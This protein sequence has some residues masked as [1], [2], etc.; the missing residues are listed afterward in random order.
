MTGGAGYAQRHLEHSDYYDERQRVR[1]EWHGRGAELLGLS[2]KVTRDQFEAVR[3]AL[4]PETGEFL[5]PRHSADRTATNGNEQSKAR[6][7]YD[8]TFS[9]PKSVSIQ[10]IVGGDDRLI[11]AHDK[12]VREAFR[13]AET[14]AA[15][16]VRLDGRN[17]N[18]I[19]AN[20][21]VAA[22]RHDASREL[23]PQ[24]HT[25]AVAANLSY[26]GVEGRWKALQASGLYERR[27][28][29]TEVYRNALAREVRGLGYDI[30]DRR[31]AKGRDYGFEIRGLSDELL[32]KYSQRSAQRDDAI[33]KFTAENGRKPTD[34][35]VAVLVR[36]SRPEK[37]AEI[38]TESVREEQ[39]TRLSPNESL[40]LAEL[41]DESFRRSRSISH[42][43]HSTSE[44]Y[45]YAKEHLFERN[46]VA[47]DHELLTE[48]LR[49]S[50]GRVDLAE[51]RG[52][53]QAEQTAGLILRSGD[54]VATR[55]SLDREK[56]I[57]AMVDKGVGQQERLGRNVP[58]A[59]AGTLREEQKQAVES[60]LD[61][62]EFAINLRGA[63]GTGKT[64]TL[65]EI[66]RGLRNAGHEVVAVAPTR[67]AVEELR[68]VG[69]QDAMTVARLLEDQTAQSSLTRK[70]LI[71]DEA[72]MISGRQMESL[73]KL[74]ERAHVRVL[75]SGDTRQIQS[76]EA[77]D[78]L[79]ILERESQMKSVS[80]NAVQRQIH[81]EYR[82][83]IQTL[84][85][86]PSQGFE[87]LDAFGAIREVPFQDRAHAIASAYREAT[88]DP[89][90][91]VLVVAATHEEIGRVTR[92]IRD[93]LKERGQ[94]AQGVTVDRHIPLQWTQAQK[95]DLSN[96]RAGQV[97]VFHRAVKG[98][99]KHE[100]LEVVGREANSLTVRNRHGEEKALTSKQARLFSVHECGRIEVAPGDKLLLTG[101]RKEAGFR[102][103]N[104]ELVRVKSVEQGKIRLEDGRSLPANYR[105]FDH[106]YAVTAHR[107][108]GK[109]VDSVIVSVD[110]MKQELFYVAASRGRQEITVITSDKE[111]LRESLGISTARPSV[112]ELAR[113][114][115]HEHDSPL[116]ESGQS[117][118]KPLE[119]SSP[120]REISYDRSLGIGF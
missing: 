45:R 20:L 100:T 8:L 107:S 10:A 111:Q 73:L 94:L 50:R 63:A 24:L 101:N 115:A 38:S 51:L 91:R 42:E 64:A 112:T 89:S 7:L 17:E 60:I 83:A 90:R 116:G 4:H 69:F 53:L 65:Q 3:E 80:L 103:T 86:S 35:E 72:G 18:R 119:V 120:H 81:P 114:I 26:D 88:S 108:Q 29:L 105:D 28:Y 36:E 9:A 32:V 21:V 25:H 74:A 85:Q 47:R 33:E 48:A 58:F 93:D 75:F 97:V 113:S 99:E 23:D 118:S 37:L 49:Q 2:E 59:T 15:A 62:R 19:T 84:R 78:A 22:Y 68:K 92:A 106:G 70:V 67:S 40:A 27:A 82:D 95:A 77:S 54:N 66:G 117:Q 39:L 41:R 61:S 1:G 14:H 102:A 46:S 96:Y 30:D 52:I 16:R 56:Q 11:A 34:N 87:K 79:R 44:A 55:E 12:A 43:P 5:R 6:S 76:V 31:D 98:I 109:T 104:G 13:E 110:A 71:V 57:V